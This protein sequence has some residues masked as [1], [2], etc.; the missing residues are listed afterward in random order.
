MASV[1]KG[2]QYRQYY[3]VRTKNYKYIFWFL[4]HV[5]CYMLSSYYTPTTMPN[6]KKRLKAYRLQLTNIGWQLQ[7]SQAVGPSSFPVGTSST[8]T[9]SPTTTQPSSLS[10]LTH[11]SSPTSASEEET[12]CVLLA[13]SDPPVR[14]DM[15][16]YCKDCQ[17]QL[18]LCMTGNEDESDCFQL[19]HHLHL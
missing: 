7:Q 2:D 8:H 17:G 6:D 11:L 12:V 16:W 9:S 14:H 5:G 1:D 3:R 18:P 15:L 19:C 10:G 4:F 13:E